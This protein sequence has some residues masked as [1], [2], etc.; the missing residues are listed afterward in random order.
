MTNVADTAPVP[1]RPQSSV[2]VRL[3][4]LLTQ[5]EIDLRLAG[6]LVALAAII[7]VFNALSRGDLFQP[8][9]MV[10]LAIQATSVAIIGTGMV[11]VIVSRNIDLSVGSLTGFIAMSY[12]LLMTDWLPNVLGMGQDFPFRWLIALGIGIAIGAGFGAVQGFIVAYVGVPSF[13]VT[14]GGLLSIR[15]AVWYLSNGAGVFGLDHDFQLLSGGTD[16]SIGATSAASP[17]SPCS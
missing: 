10:T 12:A 3:R 9:N 4:R 17:S 13:V 11:L 1:G 15:G 16:G 14:L 5:A 2:A 8:V 6:M 7:G